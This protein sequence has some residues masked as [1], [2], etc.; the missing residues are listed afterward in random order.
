MLPLSP[1][2]NDGVTQ[3]PAVAARPVFHAPSRN[4]HA[5]PPAMSSVKPS[6]AARMSTHCSVVSSISRL[7]PGAAVSNASWRSLSISAA[8]AVGLA[9]TKAFTLAPIE[10][11]SALARRRAFAMHGL[12]AF[13]AESGDDTSMVRSPS[14]SIVRDGWPGEAAALSDVPTETVNVRSSEA[15]SA[16]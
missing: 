6:R 10:S 4:D 14:A 5:A 9:T 13:C 15:G 8:V 2:V 7:S 16:A 3:I 1:A 11:A 12:F